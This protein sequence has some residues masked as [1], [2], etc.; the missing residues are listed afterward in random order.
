MFAS[1]PNQSPLDV[2]MVIDAGWE[3][4][5]LYASLATEQIADFTQD[6][7]VSRDS[8]C[9]KCTGIFIGGRDIHVV[10]D[11]LG[12]SHKAMVSPF[13]V[14]VFSGPSG[15]FIGAFVDVSG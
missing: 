6:A 7:I 2:N 12:F 4:C 5:V 14:S 9:V 8:K 11:M 10:M 15:A 1:I 13:N 3:H